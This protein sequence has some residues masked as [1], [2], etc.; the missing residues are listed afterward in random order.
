MYIR[1]A[2]AEIWLSSLANSQCILQQ[3]QNDSHSEPREWTVHS[4]E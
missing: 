1:Q 2:G 3:G 4:A